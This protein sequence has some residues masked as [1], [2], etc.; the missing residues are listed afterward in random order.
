MLETSPPFWKTL[1]S[2]GEAPAVIDHEASVTLTYRALHERVQYL[3]EQ[4]RGH[5]RSLTLLFAN[6]DVSSI[7]CY[8]AALDA[9]HAVF[10]SP[11]GIEHPG[12]LAVIEAYRPELIL[13][14]GAVVPPA[15]ESDYELSNLVDGYCALRRR[16]C[17][18]EPPHPS[19]AL[20][21]STSA[22]TGSAKAVRL[23][24]V[25]LAESAAQVAYAL[26]ISSTDRAL[27]GLPLSYVYGLSVLNS[28]LYR[29]SAVVLIKGTFADLGFYTKLVGAGVSTIPCVTETFEYMRR[30]QIGATRLPGLRRLTHSGSPLEPRLFEWIYHHFGREGTDIYLMYGQTEACGRITVLPPAALPGLHRSVGRAL[31]SGNLSVSDQGEIEYRGPGVMLGYATCRQE[32]A[33][34]DTL[35][36]RLHTGDMGR[37]DEQGNLFITGR[38]TRHCKVFGRRVNLDDVERFVSG[39]RAAAAVEKDSRVTIFFEGTVPATA[40]NIMEL[41]RRFQLPPQ[42]FRL[43]AL[44]ALPRTDRG[45]IAYSVLL[46]MV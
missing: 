2:H 1:R 37:L 8:L 39:A 6:N 42:S 5:S 43:N 30:L 4:I 33:L 28:G 21:L 46:S 17:T 35:Q 45:K 22:S 23:S 19:L 13:W 7:V 15:L 24:A 16:R 18:D 36:G 11:I 44:P 27:L 29:G 3:V 14:R 25:N 31:R 10:L 32:L 20:V 26:A 9:G 40:P 34:G 38:M 12:A 41:A